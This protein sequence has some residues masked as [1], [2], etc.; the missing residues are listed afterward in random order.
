[1]QDVAA[2][3]PDKDV[4]WL[5]LQVKE[6]GSSAVKFIYRLNTAGGLAPADCTGREVGE[7]VTV[8]YEAQY[9]I[10]E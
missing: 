1:V 7:V 2:P 9:W 5:R 3:Q 4:R 8:Q 6:G 10:Y